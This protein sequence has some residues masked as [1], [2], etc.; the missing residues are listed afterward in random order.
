[1]TG[2]F[3]GFCYGTQL[4]HNSSPWPPHF[5]GQDATNPSW[6]ITTNRSAAVAAITPWPRNGSIL[7][8]KISIANA[9]N[10]YFVN[11]GPTLASKIPDLGMNYRKFMPEQNEMS[12]FLSPTEESEVKKIIAE[13]KD[14]VKME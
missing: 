9:F 4:L 11:I 1:M 14:G 12:F 10:D 8:D 5:E 13:L 2:H 6:G 3:L 7:N